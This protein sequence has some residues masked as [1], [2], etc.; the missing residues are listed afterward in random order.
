MESIFLMDL[1]AALGLAKPLYV[2]LDG[3]EV[4]GL[5]TTLC[6]KVLHYRRGLRRYIINLGRQW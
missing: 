1:A 2:Y 6:K 5:A 3:L 4:C